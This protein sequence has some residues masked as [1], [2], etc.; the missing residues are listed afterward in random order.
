MINIQIDN[1]GFVN[2]GAELMLLAII[3]NFSDRNDINFV[4]KG[5]S[6]FQDK[7]SLG[8]HSLMSLQR[9][10][11][12]FSRLFPK[13]RF[14]NLGI[15]FERDINFI[16]DAGGFHIGDQWVSEQTTK[17]FFDK[18]ISYY[19]RYKKNGTKI[20]F[21]PQ[22]VGPFKKEL[23]RYY[24]TKLFDIVD[25]FIARDNVSYNACKEIVTDNEKLYLFPDFTNIYDPK[26]PDIDDELF[27]DKVCVI[28]NSKMITHTSSKSKKDYIVFLNEFLKKCHECKF[29]L[30]FLNHEGK[31]DL[32]IIRNLNQQY[33]YPV[34]NGL[35]AND[36]KYVIGRSRLVL[37]SRFHGVV[38]GLS[39]NVPTFCTSW[40]HKYEELMNEYE[41]NGIID[42]SD[43]D[44]AI[45]KILTLLNNT[46]QID[47]VVSHL[48][49][50]SALEKKKTEQMWSLVKNNM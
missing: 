35:S 17:D 12:D 25:L 43:I 44:G 7:S 32:E 34:L 47:E 9:Y 3:N 1:T 38:S 33:N 10:K 4:Y 18:K 11:F 5:V 46:K 14:N 13:S 6:T 48:E 20:I 27:T 2:K 45:S 21:L 29:D 28:P 31:G 15:Q 16:F 40:S 22:A 49:K 37:S 50:R 41:M 42:F 30:F 26:K 23:S 36:V 8:L 39:Q 19:R 24:F